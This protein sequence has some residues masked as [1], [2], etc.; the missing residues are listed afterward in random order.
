MTKQRFSDIEDAVLVGLLDAP[1]HDETPFKV[2][3]EIFSTPLKKKI[4]MTIN[5]HIDSG[6]PEMALF[7]IDNTIDE[8]P[9]YQAEWI[10]IQGDAMKMSDV[11]SRRESLLPIS[12]VKKYYASIAIEY[13]QKLL[14]GEV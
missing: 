5:K 12:K 14:R 2:D 8:T 10:D 4:A 11:V 6:D 7:I 3:T 9:Q 1:A 13:N